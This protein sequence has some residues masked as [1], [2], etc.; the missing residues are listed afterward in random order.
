M[1]AVFADTTAD[2][3]GLFWVRSTRTGEQ[4]LGTDSRAEADAIASNSNAALALRADTN[5]DLPRTLV[6]VS[7]DAH[8]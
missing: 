8:L 3:T 6:E 4:L 7:R 5:H 1:N 2:E